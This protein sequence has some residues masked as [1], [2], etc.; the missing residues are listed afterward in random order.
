MPKN[1][2]QTAIKPCPDFNQILKV[3]FRQGKPAY[4]PFYELFVDQPIAETLLGKK[5]KNRW[6]QWEF[7]Y[8]AGYDYAPAWVNYDMAHGELS[9][10]RIPNP[11]T[12]REEFD[13]YAWPGRQDI[14]FDEF[15]NIS[16]ALPKGMKIAGMNCHGGPLELAES[17]MGY[18][19]LCVLLYEDRA[20]VS[21]VFEK[22]SCLYETVYTAMARRD[23]VGI[24][25]I[26][27]DMG[28]KTQTL[29]SPD[30]LR[31]FVLPIHKRLAEIAHKNG[32]PAVLHSCGQLEKI[33]DDIIDDVK[34]DA[35]HSYEDIILP[36]T[37]AKKKYGGR[38]ALLGGYDVDRLCQ[39]AEGQ[40]RE[41]T[42]M[43][44]DTCGS[45]GGYALGSGNSIAKYVPVENYLTMLDEG[46][47]ARK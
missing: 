18:E 40:I 32:K 30:D 11:I 27:D 36:V 42:R 3:L 17:L 43:L 2:E 20:L 22:I 12:N 44:M 34:I 25:T 15:D 1:L 8:R 9:D 23:D 47:K 41:H 21:D 7:Y 4:V 37:E 16:A 39:S 31:E 6:E 24:V 38:I 13:K 45:D 29:I 46:W 5:L 35:K 19:N 26:H 28:Y 14:R 33:M 10:R